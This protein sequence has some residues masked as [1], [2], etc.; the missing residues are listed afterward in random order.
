MSHRAP[1]TAVRLGGRP[2]QPLLLLGP[3][4]GTTAQA[5][6]AAAAGH[7]TEQFQVVAWDLPGHGTNTTP[8]EEPFTMAGLAAG[9]LEVVDTMSGGLQP[10]TFHYAGVDVGGAVGLQLLLDAPGRV[11]SATLLATG[12]TSGPRGEDAPTGVDA[13]G[14]AAVRAALAGSDVRRRLGRVAAPVLAVVGSGDPPARL[15]AMREIADGVPDGRLVVV[16]GL[17]HLT[18]LDAPA[19]VARLV[20]EHA[21]GPPDPTVDD[22][23]RELRAVAGP[24]PGGA[25]PTGAGLDERSLALVTLAALVASGQHDSLPDEVR[26]ARRLGVGVEEITD[27]LLETAHRCG[28]PLAE[29]AFDTVR[30][31]LAGKSAG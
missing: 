12:A 10:P 28:V 7:L 6:W 25:G 5:T 15:E 3:A 20:R 17:G 22:L 8:L 31:A 9:V 24:V 26:S 14:Y 19:E 29:A 4:L 13:Q 30:S 16:E 1:V 11:E 21:L 27:L 23:A 2:D 18:P